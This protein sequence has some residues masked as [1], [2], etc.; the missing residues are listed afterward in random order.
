MVHWPVRMKEQ[1]RYST[2]G[3]GGLCVMIIGG[4]RRLEWSA[5][6]WGSMMPSEL[7]PSKVHCLYV[8]VMVRVILNRYGGNV[9]GGGNIS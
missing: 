1:W 2:T 4:L 9:I 6:C 3:P 5:G 7:T 8:L